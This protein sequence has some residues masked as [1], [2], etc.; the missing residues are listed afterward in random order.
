M[1]D[2]S[3]TTTET[4]FNSRIYPI[5]ETRRKI[6]DHH[7]AKANISSKVPNIVIKKER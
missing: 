1:I 6:Y 2:L 4:K 3:Q 5:P 7:P